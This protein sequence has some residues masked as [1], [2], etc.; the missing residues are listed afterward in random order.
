[1]KKSFADCSICARY[2]LEGKVCE[3]NSSDN[4]LNV[5]LFFL[6]DDIK[7]WSELK[8]YAE[9]QNKKYLITSPILCKGSIDESLSEAAKDLIFNHIFNHCKI[10]ANT[11]M[12]KCMPDHI[13]AI[14]LRSME[15]KVS[16]EMT[17]E[18]YPDLESFQ[19][20]INS[21]QNNVDDLV[22]DLNV[23]TEELEQPHVVD[24][25]ESPEVKI[26]NDRSDKEN[27]YMFTI[28]EKYYTADY[29]LIDIQQ[30]SSQSRIIYIFRTKDNEKEF[31]E[32]PLKENDFYWYESAST[33]NK[34]IESIS[35][36]QLKIGNFKDRDITLK[37][38]GS[39]TSI[40]TLHAVDYFLQNI[41]EAPTT[42][43]NLL[44]FDLEVYTFKDKIFPDPSKSMYPISAISFRMSDQEKSQIYLLNI[45]DEIDPRIDDIL[46]SKK[47]ETMTMFTDEYVMISAFLSKIRELNPDF[48]A[49][50]NSNSFDMPYLVGRM[51]KLNVQ[52]KALSPFGN[53]Y[54]DT[55]GRVIITGFVAL[56]Q[57]TLFKNDTT[58]PN[59][60]SYKLDSIA[61][62]LIGKKKVEFE[63]SLLKLYHEDI[64][65][66]IQYSLTDTDLLKDIEDKVQHV[67]LQDELRVIT[68][69]AHTGAAS[70]L[71]QAEGLFVTSMKKKGLIARNSVHTPEKE[72]LLGAYV[73][74]SKGGLYEG[75]LCDFDFTS[76]YPSIIN[77]WNIGP[78]T[79]IAKIKEDIVFD[80]IYNKDN[81]KGKEI[82]ILM[83]PVHNQIW[84]T[85][86]F[87]ALQ[88]FIKENNANINIAGTIYC[89]HDKYI[90]IFNTVITMLFEGR[91][92]YKKKMFEA[93]TSGNASK[94]TAFNGK[95]MAYKIL[96]NSL[97]GA[98]ANEHFRFYNNDLAKSITIT[99]RE[100]LKYSAVHC[101]EYMTSRGNIPDFKV[102]SNFMDKVKSLTDVIYGDT[103]SIFVYLTDYLKEKNIEVKK[104]PE[105]LE[106]IQKIQDFINTVAMDNFIQLHNLNKENS[107]IF[108]KNEY[109]MSKY[110]T[111]NGKKH[112]A[113]KI[114]S[115]EGKDVNETNIKGL[116]I[117]RSEIPPKSQQVLREILDIILQDG[118]SKEDIKSKVD[119]ITVKAK[120]EMIDL[121]EKR[122]NSIVRVVSYSKPLSEYKAMPQHIKAMLMWNEVMDV[123]FRYGSKGYLWNIK[124]IELTKAPE[125]VKFN[126]NNKF[127]SKYKISDLD[128]ICVPE[129]FG[130]LPIWFIPDMKK[131]IGYACDDRV[132]NLTEPLWKESSQMLLF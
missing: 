71:G 122:D 4:L 17:L 131:L 8:E 58:R 60:P 9:K 109:L 25:V 28:P 84:T 76:L 31:Y 87:D 102:N 7:W 26:W 16:K 119:A 75:M 111:L 5:D 80:L 27:L 41:E 24:T 67:S 23:F 3:T 53:V 44:H 37:G 116:E 19:N 93:K 74:D 129:D 45:K 128:C 91:K 82:D 69:T 30:I 43:K 39:D 38:Y 90:S 46:K 94:E 78:D 108:L 61:E 96:A 32:I 47:Y 123:D 20:Q 124:G 98:L 6:V 79:Y 105:V 65:T 95:Q 56:D 14:G 89:G 83:D 2:D 112:Y 66:F 121:V 68:T 59:Q 62:T 92:I 110:Y 70:T 34:I 1:M 64:D 99:G 35:D 77:T 106:E 13:I 18:C 10:N 72:K 120:N 132:G 50:W 113:L 33:E 100:L 42:N 118:I 49:G 130:K 125:S 54:A 114:V 81:I 117:K 101:D 86:S 85:I 40:T 21:K 36:L 55:R 48:I 127:L 73:F 103:D 126:F 29:R 97:Y 22:S 88:K 104:S 57:L 11:I 52:M 107:M 15:I 12:K 115:Q 63:G 51:K